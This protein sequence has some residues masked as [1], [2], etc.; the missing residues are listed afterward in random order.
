[1]KLILWLFMILIIIGTGCSMA[2]EQLKY[3][4]IEKE[5]SFELRQYD[6]Y[7]VA[8]TKVEGKAEDAGNVAFNR[9]FKYISGVNQKKESIAMTAPVTQEI[10]SEKIAMTAPVTQ[11]KKEGAWWICFIMPSKYTLETLPKPIDT[12][13]VIEKV[14]GKKTAESFHHFAL[15]NILD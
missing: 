9:L 1:M 11:E 15:S 8:G 6:D 10:P 7:F 14:T 5:G 12:N 4:V 3:K 13:V 2:I